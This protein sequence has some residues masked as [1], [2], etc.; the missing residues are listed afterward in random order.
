MQKH[1]LIWASALGLAVFAGAAAAGWRDFAKEI[2]SQPATQ[3]AASN[4]AEGEIVQGLREA[5][6][7]GTRNAVLQLGQTDGFWANAKYRIP[8]PNTLVQADGLIRAA[9]FGPQIDDLHLSFNRAA[10]QA[11]PVAADVFSQAVSQLTIND[12]R[13]ILSGADDAATQYFRRSTSDTLAVQFKPLVAKVTAR[14]GLVQQYEKLKAATGPL[15]LMMGAEADVDTYVTNRALSGLYDRV[16]VEE[17]A[18]RQNP[19]ARSS[20]ILKKVFGQK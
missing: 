11:V 19:A 1:K 2:F 18:I 17:K 15:S 16:A 3:Q 10:E 5:L 4:L 20:E 9:G 6:A 7:K 8:L 14:S 13:E 12:A